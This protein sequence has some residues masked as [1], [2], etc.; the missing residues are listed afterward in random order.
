[1]LRFFIKA[2]FRDA[3]LIRGRC[4]LEGGTCSDL[5]VNGVERI[6]GQVCIRGDMALCHCYSKYSH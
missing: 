1:M 6:I 4:L 5:S 3:A 2:A